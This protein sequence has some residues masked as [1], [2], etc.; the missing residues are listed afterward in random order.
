MKGAPLPGGISWA[1]LAY[2]RLT[3]LRAA[4]SCLPP[5]PSRR[6]RKKTSPR[7]PCPW[8]LPCSCVPG[9]VL[10]FSEVLLER[11]RVSSARV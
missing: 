6:P 8:W 9:V 4:K 5:C 7:E 10:E 2:C 11:F 1:I 3:Q